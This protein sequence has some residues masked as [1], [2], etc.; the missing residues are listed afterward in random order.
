MRCQQALLNLSLAITAYALTPAPVASQPVEMKAMPAISGSLIAPT[1]IAH[2][3]L[4]SWYGPGFAGRI[5]TSG[6]RFNP[7]RLTAASVTVPLGS[8]VKVEN[9]KN[10]RSVSVRINDCGPFVRGRSLDLSRRAAE[11]IGITHQGIARLRVTQIK[12]PP[13]ADADRCI[14]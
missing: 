4:A 3:V 11:K 8:V 10:G 5:T 6:E 9:P 7:H 13:R 1:P 12:V 2:E 14:E